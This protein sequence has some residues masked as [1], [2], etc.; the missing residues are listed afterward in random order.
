MMDATRGIRRAIARSSTRLAWLARRQ[1][2]LWMISAPP[3]AMRT[4]MVNNMVLRRQAVAPR[5]TIVP[6]QEAR[7]CPV[8]HIC[9]KSESPRR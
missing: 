3:P 4:A 9:T 2:A 8:L 1:R 5:L 7:G 6:D